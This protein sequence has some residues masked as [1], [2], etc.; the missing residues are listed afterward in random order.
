MIG[1]NFGRNPGSHQVL[2]TIARVLVMFA[3]PSCQ[4]VELFIF[5]VVRY[6]SP[7]V[8]SFLFIASL[9]YL[10]LKDILELYYKNWV[11][12]SLYYR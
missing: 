9:H 6:N 3:V 2:F 7:L 12:V 1:Y 5:C 10:V 8:L 4:V 11:L